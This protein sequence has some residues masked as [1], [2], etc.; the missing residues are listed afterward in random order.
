MPAPLLSREQVIDRLMLVFRRQGFEGASLA[1]LSKA[2]GL[3]RSSLYHYFPGGKEEMARAAL[4]RMDTWAQEHLLIPLRG[5]GTPEAR[6]EKFVA[7]LDSLYAHGREACLLGT[8]VHGESRLLFQEPLRA[9]FETLIDALAQLAVEAGVETSEARQRAEEAVLRIQGALI[10]SGGLD[11]NG[12]FE[13][14]LASL[15]DQLLHS[16]V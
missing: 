7:A 10:L 4:E 2:A 15:S 12:P 6:L 8:L 16:E 1:E 13:R 9:S 3:G 5:A 14:V 11:D